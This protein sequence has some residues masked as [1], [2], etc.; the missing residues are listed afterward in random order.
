MRVIVILL[1]LG[2]LVTG[3]HADAYRWQDAQGNVHYGDEPPDDARQVRSVKTFECK[4]AECQAE[5][6]ERYEQAVANNEA[7][8]EWLRE[9]DAARQA[10]GVPANPYSG[11]QQTV[12]VPY[13]LPVASPW[14]DYPFQGA[15][16]RSP[17]ARAVPNGKHY[18]APTRHIR[19][20]Y[21]RY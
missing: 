1:S 16:Y 10:E 7:L 11:V 18:A 5:M 14:V 4:T 19:S 17:V 20:R 13:A 9:I 8:S 21:Q 6:Q 15:H 3:A 12:L 2:L